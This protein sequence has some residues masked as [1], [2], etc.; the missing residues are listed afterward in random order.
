MRFQLFE[1]VVLYLFFSLSTA[2]GPP[3]PNVPTPFKHKRNWSTFTNR[4]VLNLENPS[5]LKKRDGTK[6]VF[7]HH[8]SG[9]LFY[10]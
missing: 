5:E 1:L 10:C 3:T 4:T 8:V 2:T 7:M 6:Y 9:R